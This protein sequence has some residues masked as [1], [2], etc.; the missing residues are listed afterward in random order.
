MIS[1][2]DE[3]FMLPGPVPVHPRITEALD[4]A[5][6]AHRGPV[7]GAVNAE[8][9]EL[10][11][12]A[13]QSQN[14][15]AVFTGSG[16]AGLEA[17]I[18]N[19]FSRD[20]EVLNIINGK[21]GERMRDITRMTAQSVE[22]PFPWGEPIDLD[23][24][25]EAMEAH[26]D[27]R[28]I[29]LVHNET[30]TAMENPAEEIGKLARKHD[31]FFLLDGITSVG[32]IPVRPDEWG[33]DMVVL[34]SQKCLGAPAGLTCLSVSDRAFEN[35]REENSYYLN[36]KKQIIR[37][38]DMDQTPYTPAIPLFLAF[39]EAL[40]LLKEEGIENRF[41]RI[42]KLARATRAAVKA[43]DLNL[44]SPEEHAAKTLT[45]I[46][47]PDGIGDGE[48]RE[49]LRMEHR[50]IVAGAQGQL[51]GKVFR[52]GHM[53]FCTFTD[54]TETFW[55]IEDTLRSMGHEFRR[56][57]SVRSLE[58]YVESPPTFEPSPV[59]TTIE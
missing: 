6:M 9:R 45:A 15:V 4:T 12:Y 57:E 25:A 33:I 52:I 46:R 32:G 54:L 48:F 40:R 47:Y 51:K 1:E 11:K 21:F 24:V 10:L 56:G 26:P 22:V 31:L 34:G 55:A 35:L 44:F 23:E 59:H 7:F 53:A 29:T 41:Q 5:F 2:E 27:A 36:L 43:I 18:S 30:S 38:R 14:Q 49:K 20:D 50:V 8:I 58:K 13:F 3:V 17:M 42:Q 28:G 16:T 37:M 19:S 39:R